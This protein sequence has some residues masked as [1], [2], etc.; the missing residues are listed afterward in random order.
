MDKLNEGWDVLNL[1][2]IVRLYETRDGK[3]GIPG[4][5]TMK[6]AQLIGRGARYCPFAVEDEQDKYTRKYDHDLD[7]PLRVCE[8]LF[9]HC[10]NEPRYISELHTA[11]REIGL[12]LDNIVERTYRLKESFK[13]DDLYKTGILFVNDREVVDRRQV[14][15]LPQAV[16]DRVYTVRIATGRGGEDV[17]FDD[18]YDGSV[19]TGDVYT[20][21]TTFSKIAEINNSIVRKAMCKYDVYKFNILKQYFPNL[22]STNEFICD[23]AYLGDIKI[24]L[25]SKYEAPSPT[26]LLRACTNVLGKI[27]DYI[28]GIE[29][30]YIGTKTFSPVKISDVFKNKKCNY[31]DP[32]AGGVGISQNDA[33][34]PVDWKIDL[35]NEDWFVFEDNYGTSEEKAFVAY[36]KSYAKKLKEEYDKVYLLR[37]ERQFHIYSFDDGGRFEP[38]YVLFLHKDKEEGFEQLQVFIE[39][40]GT[41]LLEND[42]W[43]ERFLVYM[44]MTNAAVPVKILKDDNDYFIWGFHFYNQDKRMK[45]FTHDFNSLIGGR[46]TSIKAITAYAETLGQLMKEKSDKVQSE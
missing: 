18:D 22:K 3:N 8:E 20:Y 7:N 11:L 23:A 6:E 29:E 44:K 9:Y 42:A 21:H 39:P 43:K 25:V 13:S 2:D 12:D 33:S 32:H 40:K 4:K 28:T 19:S 5:T 17:I 26:L 15:D 27:A 24:D 45:E 35:S 38:D 37:N 36:F 10:W 16:R 31:T 30:T 14:H 46:G 34:V 1:F 41:H